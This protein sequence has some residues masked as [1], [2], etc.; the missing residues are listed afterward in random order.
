MPNHITNR[1]TV[2]SG[3]YDLNTITSFNDEI[4]MPKKIKD[5]EHGGVM[6]YV[7]RVMNGR[8]PM[9]EVLQTYSTAEDK[10]KILQAV[11]NFVEYGAVS[12][13]M[14]SIKNWGTKWDMYE[15]SCEDNVLI[16][17]T[18][19]AAPIAWATRLAKTLPDNVMLKLEWA[20]ED[21]SHNTGVAM[22]SNSH[23]K[24]IEYDDGS[25]EAWELA[26]ELKGYTDIYKKIDGKWVCVED[27]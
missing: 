6:T 7:E 19:W 25:D 16:F 9:N 8:L 12:W 1:I 13:F 27:E 23:I 18:A 24:T 14:W 2:V 15:R 22:L 20:D 21:V 11:E 17:D 5:T 4:P 26:I 10:K 3:T